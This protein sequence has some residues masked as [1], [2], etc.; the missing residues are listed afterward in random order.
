MF[1]MELLIIALSVVSFVIFE[2]LALALEKL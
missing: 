2:R 1:W